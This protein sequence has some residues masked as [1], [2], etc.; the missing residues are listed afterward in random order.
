MTVSCDIVMIVWNESEL[1]ARALASIRD[2]ADHSYRL[3]VVD[4]ASDLPTS[5]MLREAQESG[6]F[7]EMELIRNSSN[8]GWL[9]GANQG[10]ARTKADY[11]CLMNNDI[12]AASGWLKSMINTMQRLPTAGLANPRGNELSENER[13]PDVES[14]AHRLRLT[15]AGRFTELSHCT[16]YCMLIK[17]EVLEKVGRFDEVYEGGYFE[18]NDF[19][20]RAY[21]AG[22]MCIRCDDAY[23]RHVQSVSFKKIPAER[24]RLIE[25]NGKIFEER[26]GTTRRLLI[27]PRAPV[28][29]ELLAL[30]RSGNLLYVVQ[31]KFFQPKHLPQPHFNIRFMDAPL[32]RLSQNLYFLFLAFYLRRKRRIDA[33]LIGFGSAAFRT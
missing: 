19:S 30:A 27:L 26:W 23:V 9:R 17:R 20:R 31:N 12:Y 4:N 11:V 6:R 18:D 25:R 14:Y 28:G 32:G 10:F 15:Q 13:E 3:I 16:G 1:T 24:Q 29:D 7:G 5:S 8:L 21:R 2:H 22:Y 33:A